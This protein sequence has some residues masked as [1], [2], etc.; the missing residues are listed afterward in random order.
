MLWATGLGH[1]EHYFHYDKLRDNFNRHV[2]NFLKGGIVY[3]NFVTT[4]SLGYA[5]EAMHTGQGFGLG[6][7]CYIHRR[8]F[9]GVRNGVDYNV[10]NP[11][12][13]RFIPHRYNTVSLERKYWNKDALRERLR[14]RKDFKP[15]I[16]YVGRLDSQ[17][18]TH[19]LDS[20]QTPLGRNK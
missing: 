14:L 13:D 7:T 4:V 2:I 15:L 18:A 1:P 16:A 6:H 20:A 10:W 5:W 17:F 8:K 9:G 11:E 12:I 3:S 19:R